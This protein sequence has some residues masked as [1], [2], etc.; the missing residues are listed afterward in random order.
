MTSPNPEDAPAGTWLR[1]QT[2]TP[3]SPQQKYTSLAA[4]A[5]IFI[6]GIFTLR[7]FLPALGWTVILSIALWPMFCRLAK[8]WP[9]HKRELLP[10]LIVLA[11]ILVFVIPLVI[12]AIP[13]ASDA[14]DASQFAANIRENG[15][16]PPTLL[17]HL[18]DG[19]KLTSLWQTYLSQPGQITAL[20]KGA[21]HGGGAK[22]AGHLGRET[23]HRL[24]LL[25]FTLLGLFFFLRDSEGVLAQ[26]R[27]GSRRAF[28]EAGEDIALQIINSV[29]GTVNGLVLVGLGEGA[30][31]GLAYILAG[32]PESVLFG[33][34]T[35]LLAMVP[36]GAAI[37]IA[38][39]VLTLF[40]KGSI[41]GALAI[42]IFGSV[43][44]FT[45]DHFIRPALIGGAT[46]LPFLW[47]LLGILGGISAWGLLGLFLGPALMAAL[48]LL[49][50]EWTGA[51]Q[52]PMNPT[53]EEIEPG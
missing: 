20:T 39:A 10:A 18:P 9:Q 36:F 27:I 49:W 12:V 51:Q 19:S 22:F 4:A 28:G 53:A 3:L 13:L 15:I 16:P 33:F 29:H 11:V 5:A 38:A 41:A 47:V 50:R 46:R 25:G 42:L 23:L 14:H 45:A 6:G 24:V 1:H 17:T 44:T 48:I 43:V 52:G 35:A 40:A 37:A 34:I 26:L 21:I 2:A 31:L 8:R 32:V 30:L 7:D